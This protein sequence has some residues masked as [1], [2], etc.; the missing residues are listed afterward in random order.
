MSE[1]T[2]RAN[3]RRPK[4]RALVEHVFA[5]LK[6]RCGLFIRTIGFAQARLK[7]GMVNL[8]Y[9]MRRLV[10]LNARA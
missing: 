1:R 10:W 5:D 8:T 9:N 4:V 6:Q 7:V 2:A 3:G